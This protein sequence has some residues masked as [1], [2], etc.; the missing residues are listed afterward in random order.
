LALAGL[1]HVIESFLPSLMGAGA[2]GAGEALVLGLVLIAI[3]VVRPDGIV[4]VAHALRARAL[5]KTKTQ[6]EPAKPLTT[7]RSTNAAELGTPAVGA[8]G[9]FSTPDHKATVRLQASGVSK[10][11]GGVRAVDSVD[12]VLHESEILAV[13]GP[14]GA[15]KST[16]LN[17]LS[18]NTPMDS[19][20]VSANG[21]DVTKQTAYAV[22]GKGV[23]RTFQTPSLF[24]GVDVRT[25]VLIG[26][27]LHGRVGLLRSSVPTPAAVREERRLAVEAN[28]ALH[29]L[30]LDHLAAQEATQLSLG[31]QKMVEVARALA[32]GPDVLLLDEPGAGLTR[33]E[34]LELAATLRRLRAQGMA[35]LLIEHDMEFVMSVADRVQVLNF[36]RTLTVGPPRDV[37]ANQEVINAYLGVAEEPQ[38]STD[39]HA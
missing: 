15:G 35:L 26:A 34:K 24:P 2:V 16:L 17:L 18:G 31:Q 22:A 33:P 5:G 29:E 21:S 25:N 1:R 14:N 23:A 10:A 36:G 9:N 11:Y 27:H 39:A 13:I 6:V 38:E 8:T 30:G 32:Q 37:Q 4:G 19:G 20:Q 7:D 3:L 12:V 28:R